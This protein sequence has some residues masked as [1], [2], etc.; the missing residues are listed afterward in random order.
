MNDVFGHHK[1]DELIQQAADVLSQCCQTNDVVARWGGDEFLLLL[2]NRNEESVKALLR[3][4]SSLCK[5]GPGNMELSMAMGSATSGNYAASF[6]ELLIKA[7]KEMYKNKLLMSKEA[8]NRMVNSLVEKLETD[9]FMVS[10]HQARLRRMANLFSEIVGISHDFTKMRQ[11]ELLV[12]I[13]DIGKVSIPSNILGKAGSLDEEE[14]EIMKTHC[15]IGYRMSQAIGEPGVAEVILTSHERW[16]GRG[17]P[18]GL[19]GEQIPLL[20]R[21]LAILATFDVMTHDRVYKPAVSKEEAIKE[22]R[23]NGGRQFDPRLVQLFL[24]HIS[25]IVV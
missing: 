9:C 11:L 13:H 16:D 21:I 14:W 5:A 3:Q 17:Y 7:E 12:Q 24:N 18:F 10:G 25:D 2:P 8:K 1:G 22:I 23:I 20:S 15:E 4:I 19:K 6:H